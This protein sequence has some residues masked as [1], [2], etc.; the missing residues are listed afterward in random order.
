MEK[1]ENLTGGKQSK[2][3]GAWRALRGSSGGG[4]LDS[5][6]SYR[7]RSDKNLADVHIQVSI[8]SPGVVKLEG[9]IANQAQRGRALDLAKS[10]EGVTDA[11][12]ALEMK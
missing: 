4:A 7:L 6:V 8:A 3:A 12:D 11:V 10:T 1:S 9:T 2:L 5:R